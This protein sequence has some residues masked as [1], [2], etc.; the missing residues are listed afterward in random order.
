[1]LLSSCSSHNN[2]PIR[3]AQY[4]SEEIMPQCFN[5]SDDISID[6]IDLSHYMNINESQFDN[7]EFKKFVKEVE[8]S[9]SPQIFIALISGKDRVD[10]FY[11]VKI[12]NCD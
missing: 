3:I 9:D 6:T 5:S 12:G 11:P 10:T 8:G 1:M 7:F 2:K 4:P